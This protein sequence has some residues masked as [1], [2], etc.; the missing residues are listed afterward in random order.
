MAK[1]PVCLHKSQLMNSASMA[2]GRA[3]LSRH[4]ERLILSNKKM[5]ICGQSSAGSRT[6]HRKEDESLQ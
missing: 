1:L 6:G 3:Q 5:V 2:R 4:F